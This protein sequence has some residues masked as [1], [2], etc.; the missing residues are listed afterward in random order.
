ME[1]YLLLKTI[2]LRQNFLFFIE[3]SA[4]SLVL[5]DRWV[6]NHFRDQ[7]VMR[8]RRISHSR[9]NRLSTGFHG[10]FGFSS[11]I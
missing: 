1:N 9:E 11:S 10:E 3:Q 5:N 2:F 6:Y 8:V 7:I 4:V